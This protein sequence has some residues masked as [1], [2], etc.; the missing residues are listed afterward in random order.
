MLENGNFVYF[1]LKNCL[2][3]RNVYFANLVK[4]YN[5]VT[6][7]GDSSIYSTKE[8]LS[9]ILLLVATRSIFAVEV[10]KKAAPS[11]SLSLR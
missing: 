11:L 5:L 1:L 6:M 8:G 9:F 10:K 4:M 2:Q 3:N 7:T